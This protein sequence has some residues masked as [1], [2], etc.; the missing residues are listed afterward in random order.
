MS[1]SAPATRLKPEP[2]VVRSV[3]ALRARG[4][5]TTGQA[6]V[7]ATLD[8][9]DK[10]VEGALRLSPHYYNTEDEVERAADALADIVEG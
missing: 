7:D 5:N 4:I 2:E 6:S 10:G 1:A 8:Y 9:G 3:G